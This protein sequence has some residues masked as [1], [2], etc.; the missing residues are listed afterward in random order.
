M[1]AWDLPTSLTVGG[2]EW[3]IRSDFR[4]ALDIL[5]YFSDPDY[6]LDEKWYICLDILYVNADKIPSELIPEAAEKATWFLDGGENQKERKPQPVLMNWEQDAPIIVPAVNRVVG[7]EIR[8]LKYLHWWSFLGAY[9][10]IGES[11]YTEVLNI[12]RK[13]SKNKKLE[14]WE[15]EFYTNNKEVI[16][17][18]KV[19][20]QEVKKE[21]ENL[22]KW[23]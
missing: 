1:S 12:R 18:K 16:D 8:S 23:L 2:I 5:K 6:E 11:F 4:V 13:R 3:D 21:K 7:T 17:L 19:E 22:M 10:E 9:M 14:K 15:Q 20:S